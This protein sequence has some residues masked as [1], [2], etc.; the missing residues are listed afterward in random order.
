MIAISQ[1]VFEKSTNKRWREVK[2]LPLTLVTN[3][4]TMMQKVYHEKNLNNQFYRPK[5]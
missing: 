1:I 4:S 2:Y 5:M 3:A